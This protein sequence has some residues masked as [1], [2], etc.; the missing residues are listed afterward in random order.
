MHRCRRLHASHGAPLT[1]L[2]PQLTRIETELT[3]ARRRAHALAGPLD[4]DAWARRPAP[5]EWSVG[6]CLIHLN[7]TSRAFLPL[8]TNAITRGRDLKLLAVG[9]YRRDFV[10]WLLCHV[11]EPPVRLQTKTTAP[12]VPRDLEPKAWVLDAFDRL[13]GELIDCLRRSEWTR[14]RAS[15][16]RFPVRRAHQIQSLLVPAD[17]SRA[18]APPSDAGRGGHQGRVRD[19]WTRISNGCRVSN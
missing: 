2:T 8:I 9:P 14:S 19:S 18:S 12:F 13:Q 11:I 4:Q 3:E 7:L 10:G 17:H 16:N 1:D 15:S 6:E 5:A